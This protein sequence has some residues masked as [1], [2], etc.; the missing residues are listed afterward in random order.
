M[1]GQVL[2]QFNRYMGH[3]SANI[4]GVY[5]IY[6]TYDQEGAVYTHVA[7][8]HQKK[9]NDNLFKINYLQHQNGC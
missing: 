7:K 9:S 2:G 8:D 1:Y 4:G 3:V 5:E 6:K